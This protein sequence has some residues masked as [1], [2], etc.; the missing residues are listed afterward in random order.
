[1]RYTVCWFSEYAWGWVCLTETEEEAKEIINQCCDYLKSAHEKWV[2][3]YRFEYEPCF[4]E[5]GI[6]KLID[7]LCRS[8][9]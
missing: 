4:V 6:F 1:M 7:D 3:Y 9:E 2:D 8:D 5:D